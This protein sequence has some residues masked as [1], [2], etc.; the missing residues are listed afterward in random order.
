[1]PCLPDQLYQELSGKAKNC[2]QAAPCLPLPERT[3][4][5]AA[6]LVVL[7]IAIR[8]KCAMKPMILSLLMTALSTCAAADWVLIFRYSDADVYA[9]PSTI[10]RVK[11]KS[12]M[13]NLTDSR[14]DKD[15]LGVRYRSSMTLFEYDCAQMTS[16]EVKLMYYGGQ[17]GQGEL[18]GTS[19]PAGG[20]FLGYPALPLQP[21]TPAELAWKMA[22]GRQ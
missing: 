16:R 1:L 13:W 4:A 11:D 20:Y 14:K 5:A 9:N 10:D 6:S 19:P 17:M 8:G 2:R 18:S 21:D 15:F 22:C 3:L 12:T 7:A